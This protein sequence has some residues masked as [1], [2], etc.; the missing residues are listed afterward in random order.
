MVIFCEG[1]RNSGKTYL[2]EKFFE[3]N[4]DPNIIYYKFYFAKYIKQLGL[5]RFDNDPALHYFSLGNIMTILELNQTEFK[6]KILV[7]D[8]SIF[9]AYVWAQLRNRLTKDE[10]FAEF[11]KIV[12]DRN[13]YSNTR[14]LFIHK[15]LSDDVE[16][17]TDKDFFDKF[18]DYEKEFKAFGEIFSAFMLEVNDRSKGNSLNYFANEFTDESVDEFKKQLY[19]LIAENK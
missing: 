11:K 2:I 10:A 15:V 5:Q 17:R 19:K 6:D 9:S 7:F 14:V 4:E 8:R 13:L 18:E 3:Q 1:P 12:N 16:C